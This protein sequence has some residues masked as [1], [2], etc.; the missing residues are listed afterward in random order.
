MKQLEKYNAAITIQVPTGS[1]QVSLKGKKTRRL[2]YNGDCAV[3]NVQSS[4]N[5][6]VLY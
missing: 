4:K 1:N 2:A 5:L 3:V 6:L